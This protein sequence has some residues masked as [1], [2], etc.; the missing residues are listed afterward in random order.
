V[1]V[2]LLGHDLH[3]LI[4]GPDR[5]LYFSCGDRGFHVETPDG[6]IEHHHTGG[7]LRCN[8]DGTGLEVVHTGLR[9]P[10]ELAFDDHGNLWTCD[11]NSDSGDKARWVNVVPG[12]DSGWRYSYQWIERPVSP[13]PW[14]L[15]KLWHPMHAGQPAYIVPPIANVTSGPSGLA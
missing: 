12:G 9:N 1:H 6:V 2:A 14:N 10:Q 8:L 3:G 15:E 5:R 11:N 13:G 7:V 4:V